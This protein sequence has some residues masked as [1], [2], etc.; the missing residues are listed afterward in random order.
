MKSGDQSSPALGIGG[1]RFESKFSLL[2]LSRLSMN[3]SYS[4][5]YLSYGGRGQTI[6]M[7]VNSI[8][9]DLS[10]SMDLNVSLAWVHQPG[11][12]LSGSDHG[13]S[14]VGEILPGFQFNYH[15]SDK[16]HLSISYQKVPGVYGYPSGLFSPYS[17][18]YTRD[19]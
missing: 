7:Y 9:Y 1:E 3:H 11:L 16:F 15:P 5:S 10:S 12:M 4:I 14:S 2:D 6:G 19:R 18:F 13:G 8:R 17:P